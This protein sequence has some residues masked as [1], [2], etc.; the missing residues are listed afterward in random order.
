M[1]AVN[2]QATELAEAYD[3][4]TSVEAK[5]SVTPADAAG[6]DGDADGGDWTGGQEQPTGEPGVVAELRSEGQPPGVQQPEAATDQLLDEAEQDLLAQLDAGQEC[7]ADG[8]C[9]ERPGIPRVPPIMG[10]TRGGTGPTG[11][12]G[13][14]QSA[15][16]PPE[17]PPDQPGLTLERLQQMRRDRD[18]LIREWRTELQRAQGALAARFDQEDREFEAQWAERIATAPEEQRADLEQAKQQALLVLENDQVRRADLEDEALSAEYLEDRRALRASWGLPP[19]EEPVL[20][21]QDPTRGADFQ[22]R[23]VD[24][25]PAWQQAEA[26]GTPMSA[27]QAAQQLGVSEAT[28]RETLST[29]VSNSGLRPS[30]RSTP[31]SSGTCSSTSCGRK[32]ASKATPTGSW[33]GGCWAT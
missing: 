26:Q 9:S 8:G 6:T 24:F 23:L 17:Q 16:G 13:G 21:E 20:V 1:L 22:R 31:C 28:A 25:R 18:Q 27:A 10:G 29:S 19:A 33:P 30:W 5:T 4:Q 7:S 14:G 12:G 32:W 3:T 15:G 2:E 11:P